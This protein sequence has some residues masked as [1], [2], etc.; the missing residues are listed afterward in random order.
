MGCFSFFKEDYSVAKDYFYECSKLY[1][2]LEKNSNL[3]SKVKFCNIDKSKLEGY[4]KAC[5]IAVSDSGE[6]N[7]YDKFKASLMNQYTVSEKMWFF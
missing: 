6:K 1:E 4:C 2:K 3:K 5:G 7:V